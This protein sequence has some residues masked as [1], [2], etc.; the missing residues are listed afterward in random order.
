MEIACLVL[1]GKAVYAFTNFDSIDGVVRSASRIGIASP[2]KNGLF[3]V[4]RFSLDGASAALKLAK[5]TGEQMVEKA[6]SS[7]TVDR[8]F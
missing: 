1:D 5:Q 3:Q 8:T 2:M 7:S 4:S 6:N